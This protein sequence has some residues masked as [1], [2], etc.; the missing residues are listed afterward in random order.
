MPRKQRVV[1]HIVERLAAIG[2][3]PV[4][5]ELPAVMRARVATVPDA[6][7]S[8]RYTGVSGRRRR[9]ACWV[10]TVSHQSVC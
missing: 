3:D 4:L 7:R 5:E 9:W 8:R 6:K 10:R 1:D 2:I